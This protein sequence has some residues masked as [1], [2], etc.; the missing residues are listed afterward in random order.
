MHSSNNTYRLALTYLTFRIILAVVLFIISLVDLQIGLNGNYESYEF[1]ASVGVYFLLATSA[2]LFTLAK[3]HIP[4][5]FSLFFAIVIDV[6]FCLACLHFAGGFSTGLAI[7]L[8]S[9]ITIA[10]IF[11]YGVFAYFIAAISSLGILL[12]I[13][14][15]AMLSPEQVKYFVPA[16]LL[17]GLFFAASLV[18]QLVA[19]SIRKTELLVDEKQGLAQNLAMTNQLI[20]QKM[21]TGIIVLSPQQTISNFNESAKSLLETPL[22]EG[23]LLPSNLQEALQQWLNQPNYKTPIIQQKNGFPS[24]K[25][26]FSTIQP[27]QAHS[28]I[29]LFLENQSELTQQAQ[30]IKLA[31]LGRLSASI[32][33]E[34]RNPLSTINHASQLLSESEHLETADKRLLQ[35]IENQVQRLNSIITNVLN[36]SRRTP[37][38]I[39]KINL[40]SLTLRIIQQLEQAKNITIDYQLEVDE[41][42]LVP[43]DEGQLQQVLNNLIDNA[44]THS[45]KNQQGYS[46]SFFADSKDD[47]VQ[48][49]VRDNG[50]GIK[51]ED[52]DKIFEPFYTT[53]TQGT[54]LGLYICRELCEMN[55]A[56]LDYLYDANGQGYFQIQFAHLQRR[57]NRGIE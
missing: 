9:P 8:L 5:K 35:M 53:H 47:K 54:G 31:S 48:L 13:A 56:M 41:S 22:I 55:Q 29:I 17:G 1:I 57:L 25:I 26:S 51:P 15:S 14:W 19:K 24:L 16:G 30:H 43:F 52:V 4:S 42:I 18:A 12:H 49:Q 36:I 38:N 20:L 50:L 6:A 27:E 21:Q 44:I 23:G 45:D 10:G 32:A 40:R 3:A 33:H 46:V 37:A 28:D 34:I 39:E 7:L 2:Q 11:F